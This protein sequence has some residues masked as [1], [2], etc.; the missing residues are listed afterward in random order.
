QRRTHVRIDLR[1]P[2]RLLQRNGVMLEGVTDNISLGGT[3]IQVNLPCHLRDGEEARLVFRYDGEDQVL[4]VTVSHNRGLRMR[5][6]FSLTSYEQ[7]AAL[8]QIVFSRADAWLRWTD[9][10]Q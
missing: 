1:T 2:I 6:R 9:G 8:T 7:E 4:P 3:S 10:R 5:L